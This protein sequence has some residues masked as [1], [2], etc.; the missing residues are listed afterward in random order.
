MESFAIVFYVSQLRNAGH[1][2]QRS[3]GSLV[4]SNIQRKIYE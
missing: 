2:I 3:E 1:Q 4:E